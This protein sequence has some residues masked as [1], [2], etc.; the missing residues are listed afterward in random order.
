MGLIPTRPSKTGIKNRMVRE[1]SVIAEYRHVDGVAGPRGGR[2]TET[3]QE[4]QIDNVIRI[5]P[6]I[7]ELTAL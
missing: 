1:T 2:K 5:A 6:T 4:G 3:E 7:V